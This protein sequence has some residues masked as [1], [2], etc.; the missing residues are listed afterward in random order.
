MGGDDDGDVPVDAE[1]G[2]SLENLKEEV[3]W[4]N[5]SIFKLSPLIFGA[6]IMT[7]GFR[8]GYSG[9]MDK[10]MQDEAFATDRQRK[11]KRRGKVVTKLKGQRRVALSKFDPRL[12]SEDRARKIALRALGYSSLLTGAIFMGGA[13]FIGIALN[14]TSVKEF[15]E[16]MREILPKAV[17]DPMESSVAPPFLRIREWFEKKFDTPVHNEPI[18]EDSI[19]YEKPENVG[20]D[21][22]N[23]GV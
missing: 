12:N 11:G 5:H 19:F 6:G 22:S 9:Q 17:G 7:A 2:V 13:A 3:P 14:V 23:A 8:Y 18:D 4:L 1:A 16:K 21:D 15:S 20:R 10:Y